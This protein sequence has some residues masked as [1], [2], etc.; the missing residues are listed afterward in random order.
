MRTNISLLLASALAMASGA[1]LC[2]SMFAPQPTTAEVPPAVA[3]FQQGLA[4]AQRLYWCMNIPM[5]G[6][7]R[8]NFGKTIPVGLRYD[9]DAGK[10]SL[11]GFGWRYMYADGIATWHNHNIGHARNPV[12]LPLV[13]HR[14]ADLLGE[15]D[16]GLANSTWI[17]E[18]PPHVSNGLGEQIGFDWYR[19][20]LPFRWDDPYRIYIEVSTLTPGGASAITILHADV[21]RPLVVQHPGKIGMRAG[22]VHGIFYEAKSG[23]SRI[24]Y[25]PDFSASKYGFPADPFASRKYHDDLVTRDEYLPGPPQGPDF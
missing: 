13:E 24:Q 19:I 21:D 8:G 10:M 18:D 15:L 4:G 5:G 12:R 2:A 6:G 20:D 22:G 14:V 11:D 3:A 25:N 7:T 9:L 16:Q 23:F 17:R 1:V